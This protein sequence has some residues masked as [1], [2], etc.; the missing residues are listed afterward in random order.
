M[1]KKRKG[2]D[3][4]SLIIWSACT[5]V[6]ISM[7]IPS[8]SDTLTGAKKKSDIAQINSLA[9]AVRQYK[10]EM[11]DYPTSLN[12]LANKSGDFGPWIPKMPTKDAWGTTNTGINGNG[13]ISPYCYAYTADGFAIWSLGKNKTNDSGGGGTTLP[14]S[15]KGDDDG[16][17][18]K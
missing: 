1:N 17:F 4:I 5:I 14:A 3:L 6:L 11:G 13:G 7:L 15:F 10:S 18:L 16:V 12:V 8:S 9:V 2:F